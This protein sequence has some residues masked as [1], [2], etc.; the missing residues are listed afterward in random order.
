MVSVNIIGYKKVVKNAKTLYYVSAVSNDTLSGT[1]GFT[2][3][4]AFLSEE[5]LKKH[6]V[7]PEKLIGKNG[8]YYNVKD[9]DRW[10]SGITLK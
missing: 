2:T 10:K 7:D 5:H 6:N 3:Y 9:G 1:Q 4:N 8:N